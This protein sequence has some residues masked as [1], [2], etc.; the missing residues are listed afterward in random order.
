MPAYGIAV[1]LTIRLYDDPGNISEFT[2]IYGLNNA[3]ST[4]FANWMIKASNKTSAYF[5]PSNTGSPYVLIVATCWE[6]STVC[7]NSLSQLNSGCLPFASGLCSPVINKYSNYFQYFQSLP[8]DKS[9][10]ISMSS[11][12]LNAKN[13]VNGLNEITT[14]I[15]L[16]PNTGCS[17]NSV[18]GGRSAL[19]DPYQKKT[20]VAS[21]MRNSLMAITCYS[22]MPV[23][24]TVATRKSQ[25]NVMVNL[26]EKIYKKYSKWVYWNEPQHNF[27]SNDWKERY[28]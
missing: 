21:E 27:P 8:S 10:D 28:F 17:G 19:M 11:T 9:G 20:S 6:N 2:G 13:I 16:N 7:L 26:S 4:M 14:Y 5:L 22:A 23:N 24:S 12:A 1:S 18:L 3:T 25:V 15:S